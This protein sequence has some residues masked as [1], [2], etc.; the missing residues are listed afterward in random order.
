MAP[1]GSGYL[2]DEVLESPVGNNSYFGSGVGIHDNKVI[3]GADGYR[4]LLAP[5]FSISSFCVF[6][7]QA[8]GFFIFTT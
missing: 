3:V 4:K 6:V 2:L 7:C 5:A 8:F 1:D